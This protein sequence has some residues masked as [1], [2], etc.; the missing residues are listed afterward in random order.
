MRGASCVTK[1]SAD[2]FM[3]LRESICITLLLAQSL[4]EGCAAFS[5]PPEPE[6][7]DPQPLL[8]VT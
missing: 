5:N 4:A 2:L 6:P 8:F 7:P 3:R 1:I